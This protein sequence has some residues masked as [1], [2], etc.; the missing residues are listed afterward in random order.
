[1]TG[2]ALKSVLIVDDDIHLR[3]ALRHAFRAEG[4]DVTDCSCVAEAEAALDEEVP[5]LV[6]TDVR[7][8][9]GSG[10]EVVRAA[11][12][13]APMPIIVAI[14]GKASP[15]EAFS[16]AAA[17]ARA[18]QAKPISFKKLLDEIERARS[19]PPLLDVVLKARI[20]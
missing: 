14:S 7:L 18:Y 20:L 5:D 16:V 1:M 11:S 17:G 2:R 4:F 8:T 12:A 6:V 10:I 19:S 3:T 15:P 9:D 13:R